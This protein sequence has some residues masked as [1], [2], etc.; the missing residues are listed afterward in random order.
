MNTTIDLEGR[1]SLAK[2]LQDC[3]G[4]RPGDQVVVESRGAEIVIT[5]AT[6]PKT[7]LYHEGNVLVHGGT[8]VT[9]GDVVKDDRD[10][11]MDQLCQGLPK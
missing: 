7:G 5:A 4:V 10:D 3:L 1:I 6:N 8:C 11:R 9:N 2:E